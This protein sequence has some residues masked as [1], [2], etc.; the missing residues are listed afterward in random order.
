MSKL[1][2]LRPLLPFRAFIVVVLIVSLLWVV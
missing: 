2:S 1:A